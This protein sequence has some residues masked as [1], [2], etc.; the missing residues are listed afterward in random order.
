MLLQLP[1]ELQLRVLLPLSAEDVAAVSASCRSLRQLCREESLWIQLARHQV[2]AVLKVT[3]E[4]SPR[5]YFQSVLYPYRHVLGLWQRRNL[6]YYG[7]L[8][9][10]SLRD[11]SLVFEDVIPPHRIGNDFE[12]VPFLRLSRMR[13]DKEVVIENLSSIALSDGA[14]IITPSPEVPEMKVILSNI[15]DHTLNPSE[16]RQVM[17]DFVRQV[18]GGEGEVD[19]T[20]LLLMRFVQ[21][22]HS[23]ALYSYTRLEP[24]WSE[25]GSVINPGLFVGTYGPH[26]TEIIELTVT[27]SVVGTCGTK[28]TGDPNVPF[29]EISFRLCSDQCLN[30]PRESQETLEAL[31]EFLEDPQYIEFQVNLHYNLPIILFVLKQLP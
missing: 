7:G 29:G 23:R 15:E 12:K 17:V 10:V 13:A 14:R 1:P 5:L 19:V 26:G 22:Y 16:W 24:T 8:L 31:V 30:I 28:V 27:E 21:T 9:K 3:E 11:Q 4:F 2:G 6:K 25:S 18:Y 20:D